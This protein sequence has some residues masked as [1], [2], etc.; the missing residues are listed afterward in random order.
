MEIGVERQLGVVD[1]QP[2]GVAVGP[3]LAALAANM[4]AW[5]VP[6]TSRALEQPSGQGRQHEHGEQGGEANPGSG[7]LGHL[8]SPSSQTRAAV[9]GAGKACGSSRAT[10]A[11]CNGGAAV[12]HNGGAALAAARSNQPVSASLG[13]EHGSALPC[14]LGCLQWVKHGAPLK[15]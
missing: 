3:V 11:T 2:T 8:A 4:R 13:P 12:N 14:Q 9:D 10:E 1:R 7:G 5:V 6:N 15:E